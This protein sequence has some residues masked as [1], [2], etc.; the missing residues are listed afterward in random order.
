M[1]SRS[2]AA[3]HDMGCAASRAGT[4]KVVEPFKPPADEKGYEGQKATRPVPPRLIQ[5]KK[6]EVFS[7]SA[8][9]AAGTTASAES[10]VSSVRKL[11]EISDEDA[12]SAAAGKLRLLLKQLDVGEMPSV[13]ALKTTISFAAD[14]LNSIAKNGSVVPSDDKFQSVPDEKVREWLSQTF[15]RE[16][17]TY[18]NSQ[19]PVQ[20]KF[21]SVAQ[22]VLIGQYI[23]NIYHE[24]SSIV[25]QYPPGVNE[26][27]AE[28]MDSWNFNILHAEQL[29]SNAPLRH[30]GHELFRK[31]DLTKKYKILPSCLDAFLAKVEAGYQLHGNPYHNSTH[32]A[33]VL[34]TVHYL[35]SSTGLEHWISSLEVL[36]ILLAATVHDLEHTGTTNTF[37]IQSYTDYALLYND[38][39]VLEN[40]HLNR[41]FTL[42]KEDELNILKNLKL[43][44]FRLV[45]SLVVEMVLATDMSS[46]SDQLKH[47]RQLISSPD[48]IVQIEKGRSK[49]LCLLLHMADISHPG[50]EWETH[51]EFSSR[52]VEEFFRQGDQEMQLGRTCSPLCNRNTTSVPECQLGFIDYIVSPSFDVCGD[53]LELLVSGYPSDNT[54]PHSLPSRDV[55]RPWEKPINSNKCAWKKKKKKSV[56]GG[57]KPRHHAEHDEEKESKAEKKRS[58]IE[59][60][61]VSTTETLRTPGGSETTTILTRE[62]HR[63]VTDIATVVTKVGSSSP[64]GNDPTTGR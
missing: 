49:V 53:L 34:Q 37:H 29:C 60:H 22:V 3:S 55:L 23:D 62:M 44:D 52:L 6:D 8:G 25:Q 9:S 11:P 59:T 33:D 7:L 43:E 10:T 63:V 28:Q 36:A 61:K 48:V 15:T 27:F 31:H 21:K 41:A 56:E 45:R 51:Q 64:S 5:L 32:A 38:R 14:V 47:M 46:H 4:V 35:I 54:A 17:S 2:C 20:R 1:N 19:Q 24:G 30:I 39:A 40:F 18:T 16:E 58:T 13:D 26:L 12:A 57:T 42:L 50:K